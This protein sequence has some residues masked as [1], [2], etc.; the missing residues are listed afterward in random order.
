IALIRLFNEPAG[1]TYLQGLGLDPRLIDA[2]PLAGISGAANLV[3]AVKL[4]KLHGTGPNDVIMTVLTDSIDLYRSRL[5]EL[6]A[7]HGVFSP[8]NAA[9]VHERYLAGAGTDEMLDL[10]TEE[11]RRIH[12][13]KYFTWVEQQGR[14][15]EELDRQWSVP[16][17][18]TGLA[19]QVE[20]VDA[21]IGEFNARVAA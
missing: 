17:Y 7:A 2:L 20:P 3:A 16:E 9:A 8:A 14:A 6:E 12:N 13:L 21:L 1:R 19:A 15:V 10:T 11:R 18:W 5:S 4:A